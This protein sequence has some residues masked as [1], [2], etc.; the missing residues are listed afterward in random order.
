MAPAPGRAPPRAPHR[1]P[2]RRTVDHYAVVAREVAEN[3]GGLVTQRPQR[4]RQ[5]RPPQRILNLARTVHR[6]TGRF[7]SMTRPP[8]GGRCSTTSK[9]VRDAPMTQR[10]ASGKAPRIGTSRRGSIQR[11]RSPST[12][13]IGNPITSRWRPRSLAALALAWIMTWPGSL[14]TSSAP[15]GWIDPAKWI[16]S[17]SQFERSARPNAGDIA[18]VDGGGWDGKRSVSPNQPSTQP[19]R[20]A[21]P[22]EPASA[23]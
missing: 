9:A 7:S 1:G 6:R 13:S 5:Q 14:R 3:A 15:C 2:H 18:R 23:A 12:A 16:C 19:T 10:M 17:R 20:A 21:S 8:C 4:G 22:S 11:A